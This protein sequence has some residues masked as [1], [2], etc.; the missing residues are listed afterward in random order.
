MACVSGIL[1]SR[2]AASSSSSSSSSPAPAMPPRP[3]SATV[4]SRSI[5]LR[6]MAGPLLSSPDGD[7]N[8]LFLVPLDRDVADLPDAARVVLVGQHVR[9]ERVPFL[10]HEGL[11][12][13]FVRHGERLREA[14]DL[15]MVLG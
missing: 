5:C 12:E 11:V 6:N 4:T 1:A 13:G 8:E 7:E 14:H 10:G 2:I 9:L 3:I 15:E